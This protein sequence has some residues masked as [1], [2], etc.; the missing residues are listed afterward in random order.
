[1]KRY[2]FSAS[3]LVFGL[4]LLGCEQNGGS[5]AGQDQSESGPAVVSGLKA[6]RMDK[7]QLVN[8]E[9]PIRIQPGQV[10]I[11][12]L[13]V[14]QVDGWHWD[15]EL[16]TDDQVLSMIG[17][18]VLQTD[19]ETGEPESIQVLRFRGV[20]AGTQKLYIGYLND[21]QRVSGAPYLSHEVQ[22]EKETGS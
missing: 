19:S 16:P 22:V 6:V 13:P 20:A 12:D 5:V 21:G 11:L 2:I 18:S 10:L 8:L 17:D 3:A 15:L 7:A 1:M 9:D 14:K 4:F